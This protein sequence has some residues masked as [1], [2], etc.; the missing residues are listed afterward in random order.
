MGL[1]SLLW[2]I[3]LGFAVGAVGTLLGAGGGF[4]LAPLLLLLYPRESPVVIASISLAVVF[5]NAAS[6]SVAYARMKRINYRAGLL[7]AAAAVPGALLGAWSTYFVPRSVFDAICGALMFAAGAN[8]FL[9][10]VAPDAGPGSGA[11][12]EASTPP[13]YN[14]YLGSGI[15]A[16]VGYV[17][18]MLGIGGGF[19]HVPA[20]VRLLNFPVHTATATSHFILAIMALTGTIAHLAMGSFDHRGFRQTALL[21]IGV[22][23]GAQVGARLSNLVSGSR[24]VRGLAVVL[25]LVG[26]SVFR[27][28][29][30]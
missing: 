24:I 16:I 1:G 8:L 21:S 23:V 10:P 6:G 3:P 7:F 20:M 17:S 5:F 14:S 25:L 26:A 30:Q 27:Q 13:R 19:I 11:P 2:F 15:S 4:L 12:E 18:S 9:H 29:F 22:I 28:A